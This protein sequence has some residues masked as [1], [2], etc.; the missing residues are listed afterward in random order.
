VEKQST[1]RKQAIVDGLGMLGLKE[2]DIVLVHSSLSSFGYVEGGVDTVIDA[3]LEAAGKEGTIM[4]PTLT[5]SPELSC[6]NPPVFDVRNSPCWTGKI[7]E[8]FRKRQEAIR[9]L[10][11]TH[12]VAAIGAKAEFLTQGHEKCISP[13]GQGSPYHKLAQSKGYILLLGT[14]LHSCTIFH[15]AEELAEVDYVLQDGWVLAKVID[16]N[17]NEMRVRIKIHRYGNERD[18]ARMEPILLKEEVMKTEN[19]G[20]ST[21]HLLKADRLLQITLR[22]LKNNSGFLLKMP[23][24]NVNS[25]GREFL[26]SY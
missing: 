4:V 12:S 13:C 5:G 10:H 20:K 6:E 22:Q 3:L 16:K 24:C 9:S 2:G 25:C 26:S 19:I 7:P 14:T 17:S 1:V 11:P 15:T 23:Q 18:F 21:V 8:T